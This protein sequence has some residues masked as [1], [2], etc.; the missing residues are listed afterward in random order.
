[1]TSSLFMDV[2]L[3]SSV[4]LI[5]LVSAAFGVWLVASPRVGRVLVPFGAGLLFGM[6][7]FGILPEL[8]ERAGW[9]LGLAVLA[10][11]FALVWFVDR[12]VYPVCPACSHNHAHDACGVSLHGFALPLVAAATLHSL[13]DGLAITAS[14]H[15]GPER[16]A[17]GVFAAVAVH[18]I[19]EG[20]AYGTILRAALRSRVSALAWCAAAQAPT[21][22]GGL[23]ERLLASHLGTRWMML[24]LALAGGSFLYLAFHAVHNESKRRGMAPA[25]ASALTGAAGAAVLLQG[26]R[27]FFS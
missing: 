25:F 3:V 17:W 23:S 21:I 4:T 6:A 19:P 15:E 13:M 22:L 24:P 10:L 27:V 26:V 8:V 9:S 1:V 18:K 12:F 7:A 2:A 5:A 20:L 11:G 16:L 14:R